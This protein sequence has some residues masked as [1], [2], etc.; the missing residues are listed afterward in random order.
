MALILGMRVGCYEIVGAIGAGGM[1]DIYRARLAAMFVSW[2]PS[3]SV[4]H[5]EAIKGA[6]SRSMRTSTPSSRI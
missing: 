5:E 3:C 4:A 2:W 6:P 1:G